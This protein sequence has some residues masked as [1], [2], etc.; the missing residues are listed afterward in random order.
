MVTRNCINT[1]IVPTTANEITT[2]AQ[3]AFL[4]YLG[5]TDSNVTGDGTTFILGTGNA[6]TEVFDQNSDFNVNG[7]FTAPITG[8]YCLA[9]S[10]YLQGLDGT[11]LVAVI[12]IYAGGASY[13]LAQIDP[14][15]T[16]DASNEITI[17][18]SA[19]I[20]LTAGNT[21]KVYITIYSGNKVVDIGST[22][23][24]TCFSGYL[25]V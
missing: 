23:R 21:A 2:P 24:Y 16:R 7:T 18:G 8:K 9:A 10:V 1:Y 6:L 17:S 12:D 15:K 22:N 25:A 14:I 4:A 5:T 19:L 20:N 3:P 13:R 11:Q